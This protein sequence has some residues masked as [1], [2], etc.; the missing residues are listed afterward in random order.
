MT[1]PEI[2]E[3]YRRE[4]LDRAIPVVAGLIAQGVEGGHIR[5]VDPELTV[6]S[7]VGPV[8]VHVIL[9]EVFDIRP[10][11]GFAI[12]QLIRNHVDI[13]NHGLAPNGGDA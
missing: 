4:V 7:I 13:L 11:D 3:M 1:A 8:L 12:E 10:A 6:R 2:A 5:P 9:S